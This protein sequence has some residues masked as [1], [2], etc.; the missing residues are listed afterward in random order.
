[1]KGPV[2]EGGSYSTSVASSSA[3]APPLL[4]PLSVLAA[5][6]W[7]PIR[8]AKRDV[9][10]GRELRAVPGAGPPRLVDAPVPGAMVAVSNRP[11]T[12]TFLGGAPM[13]LSQCGVC[14]RGDHFN[15]LSGSGSTLIFGTPT[16]DRRVRTPLEKGGHM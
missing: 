12:T 13:H 7:L 11:P 5:A 6:R 1:M 8:P 10:E 2:P 3:S 16:G 14:A 4:P 15:I 9:G